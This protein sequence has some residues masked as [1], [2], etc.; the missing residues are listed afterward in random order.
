MCGIAGILHRNRL[1]DAPERVRRMADSIAHRGPDDDGFWSDND[2]ALGFR[3]LSIVDLETGHQPMTNED[4]TVWVIFNG[5]IYNHREL[6]KELEAAGHRFSTDHSDTEVLVHGYEEWG[7]KLPGRLNGMFGFA[8][9]DSRRRRLMLGRDRLGIK[10]VYMAET[11][12]GDLVFASE[13]RAI[14]ASGLVAVAADDNATLAYFQNQN[15]WNGRSMFRGIVQLKA[16]HYFV[17]DPGSSREV[18]FWDISFNRRKLSRVDAADALRAAVEGALE[19]QLAADVPVMAY[20]SGG[21]DSS[22]IVAGSYRLDPRVR[23]YSCLFNLDQVGDDKMVDEREFSR[24]VAAD[25]GIEH[26]ELELEQTALIGSL[27]STIAALEEPRMGM[28]YV[29]YLIAGRVAAD[30]KVV[31]SGCGGDEILGGYVGRYSYAG[32][33]GPAAPR[34]L[35]RRLLGLGPTPG[36]DSLP[37]LERIL[38]LYRYPLQPG[39]IGNAFTPAFLQAAGEFSLERELSALLARAPSDI[40]WDQLLYADAK[41]YL[42]GL[43]MVEDKLSMAHGLEARVPLLDNEIIDLALSY[44][45]SLLTDGEVGKIVFRDAI[46]DWVPPAI[47]DKPK[48]GFGPPDASWYRG[49]LQPYIRKVLAPERIAARGVFDPAFVSQAIDAHMSGSANRLPLIWS[50]LSFD[51]WC[52]LFGVHGGDL[53]APMRPEHSAHVKSPPRTGKPSQS[54][55]QAGAAS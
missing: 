23:A 13:L 43:L 15:V 29:N 24:L 6:R 46:R 33:V 50:L 38:P 31:L 10:P 32:N 17:A 44:D 49:A 18:G 19:R 26:V 25:L 55:A 5:E 8:I 9:W 4:R 22:S 48:M 3:R 20:L 54:L 45:W 34:P 53:G 7:E 37:A 42:A 12:A 30:S 27:H 11:P 47:A 36:R 52:E 40:A 39:E 2:V 14:H 51:A 16:G 35:W 1:S 21:I 28:A 41:T